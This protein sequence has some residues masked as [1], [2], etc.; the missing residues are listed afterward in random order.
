MRI[1]TLTNTDIMIKEK[2]LQ[3]IKDRINQFSQ[4]KNLRFFIFGSSLIKDHFGDVDV[5]VM[6]DIGDSDIWQLEDE[7]ENSTL[8]Y[9]VEIKNFNKV[10]ERFKNN[11]FNNEILWITH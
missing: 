10:S 11:V 4:N 5:G 6:G 1:R 8:P 2:Y 9:F 7:F 3:Q